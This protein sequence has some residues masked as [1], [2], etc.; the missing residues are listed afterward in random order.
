[1]DFSDVEE[2][3][4]AR[5][6]ELPDGVWRHRMY[7]DFEDQI[8]PVAMAAEK[9]DD[10]LTFDLTGTARQAPAVI[11][12][13]PQGASAVIWGEISN[14]LCWDIPWCP[15]G[16]ARAVSIVSEPGTLCHAVWP[17]GSPSTIH[18]WPWKR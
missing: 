5:L 11:N 8:Y 1:M 6:R 18:P 2:R 12:V 4:R 9:R 15:A 10:S 14:S 13:S 3:F 16:V 17:A 7:I